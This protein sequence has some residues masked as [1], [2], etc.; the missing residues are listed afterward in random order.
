MLVAGYTGLI[1][2]AI[3]RRLQSLG[4]EKLILKR[5]PD[6]DFS[7]KEDVARLFATEKPDVVMIAAARVGGII[8]NNTFRSEF[9]RENLEIQNNLIWASHENGV[10]R[11][12]FLGSSCIYPRE[13]QQPMAES[14]LLTGPLE[15]TNRPYAIAKIAG[16]ELVN[17]LVT[18]YERRYFSVMP[19]NLYGPR[20][21]FHP[22]YSHVLPA[23]IRRFHEAKVAGDKQVVVWGSGKPKREFLYSE[24][25]A[26]AIIYLTENLGEDFFERM[27]NTDQRFFHINLGSGQEVRISELVDLIRSCVGY[28]GD[29]VYDSSKPDGTPR[30][31]LDTSLLKSLGWAPKISLEKGISLTYQWFLSEALQ[32]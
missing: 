19:T 4:Y 21:N 29:V 7:K 22:Q 25:C 11:L 5:R 24:D 10:R 27:K 23:L 8:A 1:G 18:Q 2:S 17:C 6:F 20:D 13:A 30:K 15:M 12:V 9:L 32:N 14:S 26:D 16:L 28:T 31:L 3:T